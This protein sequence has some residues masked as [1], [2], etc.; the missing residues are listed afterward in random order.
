MRG[1]EASKLQHSAPALTTLQHSPPQPSPHRR[2]PPLIPHPIHTTQY[3][4]QFLVHCPPH[5]LPITLITLQ[6]T[7]HPTPH[8]E[9]HSCRRATSP[10]RSA[11]AAFSSP[12]RSLLDKSA[13]TSPTPSQV[14]SSLG[15]SAS[16]VG[17]ITSIGSKASEVTDD[18]NGA[19]FPTKGGD[20]WCTAVYIQ[21]TSLLSTSPSLATC[22]PC[23]GRLQSG[24][25]LRQTKLLASFATWFCTLDDFRRASK[26]RQIFRNWA[27]QICNIRKTDHSVCFSFVF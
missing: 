25:L 5:S 8:F 21:N 10:T 9:T 1:S 22:S 6:S 3:T 18:Q 20:M 24:R 19:W 12:V 14:L 17:S 27:Q 23:A 7:P 26:N 16:E 11:T 15:P 2:H 13:T 4:S